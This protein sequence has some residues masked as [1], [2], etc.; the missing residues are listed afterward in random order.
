MMKN[1]ILIT[2]GHIIDPAR[3]INEINNLRIIN[4]IIV[5]ADKYPVTSETRII[6]ADGMIVTPGLIDYHAHVFYD[7]TEGGVRPDMYMP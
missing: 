2:G 6:H 5:D 1:D 4:D 7:A 3:N